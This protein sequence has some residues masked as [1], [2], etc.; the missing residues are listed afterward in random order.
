ML[1]GVTLGVASLT[2]WSPQA[3]SCAEIAS[4]VANITVKPPVKMAPGLV[5]GGG[6]R[7]EAPPLRLTTVDQAVRAV[8]DEVLVPDASCLGPG[9]KI[10][11]VSVLARSH[12]ETTG[13]GTKYRTWWLTFFITKE[14][15]TSDTIFG[16][17]IASQHMITVEERVPPGNNTSYGA[18]RWLF[19]PSESC[20]GG[21]SIPNG[22]Q[23]VSVPPTNP[24]QLIQIRDTYL[25]VFPEASSAFFLM[26]KADREIEI[27]GKDANITS[28]QLLVLANSLITGTPVE[29][30]IY[31]E[32][33]YSMQEVMSSIIQGTGPI[34]KD[35][36]LSTYALIAV[37][38]VAAMVLVV[39]TIQERK[40]AAAKAASRSH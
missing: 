16:G 13:N 1:V 8:D 35:T 5:M 15:F 33:A 14:P 20:I 28:Q 3:R 26:D 25:V 24:G 23:C 40:E 31:S 7:G 32:I 39:I 2:V 17:D 9:Y 10:V 34:N 27:G 37:I 6:L 22:T 11:G 21:P 12:I 4:E 30:S 19:A 29:P 38:V 36:D 18:T